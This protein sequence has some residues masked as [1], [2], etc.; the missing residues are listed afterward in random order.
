MHLNKFY[1]RCLNCSHIIESMS[2]WLESKQH[3]PQCNKNRV[4]VEYNNNYKELKHLVQHLGPDSLW[5]YFDLLPLMDKSNIVS[6]NEGIVKIERWDFIENYAKDTWGI[7]CT[8]FAHRNDLNSATG[9][10]KDLAGTVVASV[11]K[12][13]NIENYVVA[14]TGNIANAYSKYLAK[15]GV[16]LYTF[17]PENASSYQ[18]A[19]IKAFGQQAFRIKGD[20]HQAKLLA[21]QFALENGYLLA[22]GNFDPLRVEAKKILVYEWL[23]I[24]KQL[25]TI[26]IQALSG[27][28]GPLGIQKAIHELKITGKSEII[29][30]QILVQSAQCDPMAQAWLQA[31]EKEFPKNWEINYPVIENPETTIPTL[32][33]GNPKTYPVLGPFVRE[34]N[35]EII[36]SDE[37]FARTIAQLVAAET[38]VLIGPAASIP[39]AGLFQS[40]KSGYIKNGDVILLNIG[41]GVQRSPDFLQSMVEYGVPITSLAETTLFSRENYKKKLWENVHNYF[42]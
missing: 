18:V 40:F 14:S 17:L 42:S 7:D 37:K 35:G 20:Y 13:N 24:L 25:P 12:E 2:D 28:T 32:S 10:F 29:P 36:A 19:S 11:L 23:R 9:T 33:T 30:K 3:C 34:T 1:L 4:F 5:H 21:E 15:A 31:K 6:F 27:G 8:I 38:S 16:N 26:Y 39:V 22:A 41:E